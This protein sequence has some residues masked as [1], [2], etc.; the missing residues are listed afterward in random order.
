MKN[1]ERFFKLVLM[2]SFDFMDLKN[3][4]KISMLTKKKKKV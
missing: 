4:L 1:F 3:N 2:K